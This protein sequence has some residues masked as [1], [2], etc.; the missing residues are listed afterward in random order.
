[1]ANQII[2]FEEIREKNSWTE[3]DRR[4]DLIISHLEGDKERN[5]QETIALVERQ[6]AVQM[7]S[8]RD[9]GSFVNARRRYLPGKDA[10]DKLRSLD[11]GSVQTTKEK[12]GKHKPVRSLEEAG[13]S[14]NRIVQELV[15][16]GNGEQSAS[17]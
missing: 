3:A 11:K 5:K 1:M 9:F 6:D 16:T 17:V 8:R 15:P 10:A 13:L 4:F 2:S 14:V 12:T 7:K